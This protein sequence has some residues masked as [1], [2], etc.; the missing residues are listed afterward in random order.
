MPTGQPRRCRSSRGR[1]S[2]LRKS[3]KIGRLWRSDQVGVHDCAFPYRCGNALCVG[4]G[5]P[6][7][8]SDMQLCKSGFPHSV[9][10]SYL[11]HS[12]VRVRSSRRNRRSFLRLASD[13]RSCRR[14]MTANR[15]KL[16]RTWMQ[17]CVC[18]LVLRAACRCSNQHRERLAAVAL[19]IESGSPLAS[20][21]RHQACIDNHSCLSWSG[22]R[23]PG[24]RQCLEEGRGRTRACFEVGDC[25]R[26]CIRGAI[27][28]YR[29]VTKRLAA[30]QTVA[31]VHMCR[32][33][34]AAL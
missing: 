19:N 23:L 18:A 2:G 3:C 29:W 8:S 16:A 34:L 12:N 6:L 5:L 7:N 14:L 24:R 30:S 1:R 13:R 11:S 27:C 25:S 4:S 28:A 17:V 20:A 33:R 9:L 10:A 31:C 32:Q 15:P 26:Q 21:H 22:G